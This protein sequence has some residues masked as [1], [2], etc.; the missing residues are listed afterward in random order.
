MSTRH[1]LGLGQ[2]KGVEDPTV[3]VG[4]N[5]AGG[6]AAVQCRHVLPEQFLPGRRSQG[7]VQRGLT[8][9]VGQLTIPL[10]AGQLSLAAELD[11]H[12]LDQRVIDSL[13]DLTAGPQARDVPMDDGRRRR[14]ALGPARVARYNL[15]HE[16]FLSAEWPS[17]NRHDSLRQSGPRV[18]SS[19]GGSS[20]QD[21]GSGGGEMAQDEAAGPDG[22]QPPGKELHAELLRLSGQRG[23]T[24]QQLSTSTAVCEALDGRLGRT[25]TDEERYQE[26]VGILQ[27]WPQ[28]AERRILQ[29]GF[30]VAPSIGGR[31]RRA[32]F[33]VLAGQLDDEHPGR[34]EADF[35]QTN[36]NNLDYRFTDQLLVELALLLASALAR[37]SESQGVQRSGIGRWPMY[38][39]LAAFAVAVATAA[40]L[41][42]RRG[43]DG[44]TFAVVPS[45]CS[46]EVCN[47]EATAFRGE[48]SG[49]EPG[50]VVSVL[51]LTPSGVDANE[52]GGVYGY[53]N[54]L[55]A[56]EDGSVTWRYWWDPGMEVGE[57]HTIISCSACGDEGVGVRFEVTE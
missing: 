3:V 4:L 28:E 19:G 44:P 54:E 5:R 30:A 8:S 13:G 23:L 49:F 24:I 6:I 35:E 11:A 34:Q 18:G 17:A 16:G 26:L 42:S 9:G 2:A 55:V 46:I 15:T 36:E 1:A 12:H 52:L 10:D 45:S 21:L 31:G 57:Y 51:I 27:E 47:S 53:R 25:G 32:R 33:G 40:A 14:I 41:I 39:A 50:E 43:D 56:E 29:V 20:G 7:D 37:P 38:L 48:S 22:L